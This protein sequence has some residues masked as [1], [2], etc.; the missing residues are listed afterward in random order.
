MATFLPT[1]AA[2]YNGVTA[3]TTLNVRKAT[4]T[5]TWPAPADITYGTPLSAAQLDATSPVA[6]SFAYS[7]T[8][9]TV[10][11]TGSGQTLTAT[12]TPA[13]SSNYNIVETTTTLTV[14]RA[15]PVVTWP[16]PAD[17]SDGT[18]LGPA[19]LD[20]GA[21]I[22]GT[23]RYLPGAGTILHTG[24]AQTLSVV[25][26]PAD[27]S[28]YKGVTTSVTINVLAGGTTTV[29]TGSGDGGQTPTGT[30]T[31][32]TPGAGGTGSGTPAG[33]NPGRIAPVVAWASPADIV[34]G[35]P[36]G[37]AQLN[38]TA[39]V[40]GTFHY[41]TPT[42]SVLGAGAS[43]RL[44]AIFT[45]DDAAHYDSV[46]TTTT[47][48]ILKAAPV[49]AWSNPD[50][51]TYGTALGPDQLDATSSVPGSFRYELAAGTILHAGTG[52]TLTVTFTP[53][54]PANYQSVTTTA[55]INVRKAT[56]T[57]SW[58]SPAAIASGKALGSTQLD[59]TSPVAG[60]FRYT[61][62]TGT[63]LRRGAGQTLSVTFTPDDA[64]DY[65]SVT[66]TTTISVKAKLQKHLQLKVPHPGQ[67]RRPGLGRHA[68]R[69]AHLR[70]PGSN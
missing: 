9:G 30:P 48:N 62:A 66:A 38:A 63:V 53:A 50:D 4:P 55:T 2:N 35:T 51:I 34:Y 65:N 54:D 22:A 16:T 7:L 64:A 68:V 70:V 49:L 13:D 8:A 31:P 67:H 21:S 28:N 39:S 37:T 44:T 19:Q 5:V 20:A 15:T 17:V 59:A 23:F 47:V 61:P 69:A 41:S 29:P 14:L 12:F 60:S 45:P 10:L 32:T 1:D 58:P 36:L 18:A 43:Q 11:N 25:F 33:G 3:T 40:P 52:Q 56:P 24:P 46:T 26:T 42:G 27:G 57:I 6:G